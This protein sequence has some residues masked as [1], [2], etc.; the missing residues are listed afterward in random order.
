MFYVYV[1]VNESGGF[2]IGF[3]TDLS[4]RVDD[5]N[6]G[7]NKSTS[8]RS[9]TLAYFEAFRSREEAAQRERQLKK[10]GQSKRWLMER[11]EQSLE[12]ARTN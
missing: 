1:I 6:S 5:H 9:W 12:K 11:I 8:G 10:H 7:R 3:T 4:R 2:Y